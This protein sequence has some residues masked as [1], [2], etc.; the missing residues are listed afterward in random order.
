MIKNK[1]AIII[2]AGPAGL[3]NLFIMWVTIEIFSFDV[4]GFKILVTGLVFFWNFLI[5]KLIIYKE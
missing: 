2:G 3:M 5:R 4:I 1:R